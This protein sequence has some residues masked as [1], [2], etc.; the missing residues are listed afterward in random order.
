MINPF[1]LIG[2]ALE[3]IY[4][5]VINDLNA[6]EMSAGDSLKDRPDGQLLPQQQT[7]HNRPLCERLLRAKTGPSAA[8]AFDPTEDIGR[9]Q[10]A[11]S[12]CQV[13]SPCQR[14]RCPIT[15]DRQQRHFWRVMKATIDK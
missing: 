12:G 14:T 9:A 15:P 6:E 8:G 2:V 13:F 10:R 5:Y 1:S 11:M 7:F 4:N 3:L